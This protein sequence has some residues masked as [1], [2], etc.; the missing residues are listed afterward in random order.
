MVDC[1]CFARWADAVR[2]H[3]RGISHANGTL[4]DHGAAHSMLDVQTYTGGRFDFYT[5]GL[6]RSAWSSKEVRIKE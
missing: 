1:V 4:N 5:R 6:P 3:G 2:P